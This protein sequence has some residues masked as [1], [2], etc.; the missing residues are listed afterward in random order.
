MSKLHIKKGDVVYINSG[1]DKG[2][3]GRVSKVFVKE[4][5]ALVDGVNVV[6]KSVKPSAKHN[7]GGFEKKELSVH[8]SNLNVLDNNGDYVRICRKLNKNGV[9]ARFSRKS[10]EEIK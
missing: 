3:T 8:I 2:K 5:R 9:L 4:R 7:Q 6:S 10:G 1:N